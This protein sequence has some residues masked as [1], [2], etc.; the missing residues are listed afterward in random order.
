MFFLKWLRKLVLD[1]IRMGMVNRSLAMSV[2]I[3]LVLLLGLVIVAAQ[4][5]APYIYTL[6]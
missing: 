1:T 4:I 5:S 3:L 6:F 2:G